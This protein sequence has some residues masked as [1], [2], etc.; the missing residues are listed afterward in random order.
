M[1][2]TTLLMR[3]KP[4]Q[5]PRS[6]HNPHTRGINFYCVFTEITSLEPSKTDV[7]E[8]AHH[9]AHSSGRSTAAFHAPRPHQE[10]RPCMHHHQNERSTHPFL[11]C[12]P[13][14]PSFVLRAA[15]FWSPSR[16]SSLSEKPGSEALWS[17]P[18]CF[19]KKIQLQKKAV[20]YGI[21]IKR[22]ILLPMPFPNVRSNSSKSIK[23]SDVFD[24]ISRYPCSPAALW[25]NTLTFLIFLNGT[26][27]VW[28][29]LL[30]L[31]KNLCLHLDVDTGLLHLLQTS[32]PNV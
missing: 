26:H 27:H 8:Q 24:G 4:N 11:I 15:G 13:L 22:H 1:L 19:K 7:V 31:L 5:N 20:T 12:W 16:K 10:L 25:E 17:A 21:G 23:P 2:K 28:L 9:V 6:A 14:A 32:T 3:Q 18:Q 30:P 29:L